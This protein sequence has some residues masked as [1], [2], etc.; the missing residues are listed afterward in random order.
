MPDDVG[1]DPWVPFQ[2]LADSDPGLSNDERATNYQKA[3]EAAAAAGRTDLADRFRYDHM[4]FTMRGPSI[5]ITDRPRFGPRYFFDDGTVYPDESVLKAPE[6]LKYFVDRAEQVEEPGVRAT[7]F[8]F[9]WE[10]RRAG[11]AKPAECA[12]KAVS[13]YLSSAGVQESQR[14]YFHASAALNRALQLSRLISDDPLIDSVLIAM[15]AYGARL[16]SNSDTLR[17]ILEVGEG[18]VA[19]AAGSLSV[20]QRDD[21]RAWSEQAGKKFGGE[22]GDSRVLER[23]FLNLRVS[24]SPGQAELRRAVAES[25]EKE[26]QE[27]DS[28]AL[29][30]AHFLGAALAKYQELGDKEKGDELRVRLE[31]LHA[32]AETEF[33]VVTAET[34]IGNEEIDQVIAALTAG[35]IDE[36]LVRV[37]SFF[38]P[39]T[40]LAVELTN[41]EGTEA[42]LTASIDTEVYSDDVQVFR[43]GSERGRRES[44]FVRHLQLLYHFNTTVYFKEALKRLMGAGLTKG[45]LRAHLSKAGIFT[46]STL[47]A[48]ERGYALYEREQAFEAIHVL[49]PQLED[50]FRQ[51]LHSIGRPVTARNE[52][53]GFRKKS[54]STLFEEEIGPLRGLFGASYCNYAFCF[55]LDPR[56]ENLRNRIAHGLVKPGDADSLMSHIVFHNLLVVGSLRKVSATR[57]GVDAEQ[58]PD[59]TRAR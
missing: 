50:M 37:A 16:A 30:A 42:P 38:I 11:V 6:A 5:A 54:L 29:V 23:R 19:H 41:R 34:E 9:L 35:T 13:S 14:N 32:Q 20:N 7:Y 46:Q 57:Q 25:F 49:V 47:D 59:E 1:Q 31:S 33:Q 15:H 52:I 24:L 18:L 48:I 51:V 53:G 39:S 28:S 26:S 22:G 58:T 21:W 56:A 27:K 12:R 44:A 55:L 40:Q 17:Y 2:R 3:S 36:V 45:T 10:S 4:L 8:D 43:S